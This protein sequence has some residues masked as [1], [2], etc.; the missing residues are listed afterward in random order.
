MVFPATFNFRNLDV[1]SWKYVFLWQVGN[2]LLPPSKSKYTG[3]FEAAEKQYTMIKAR[4][5]YSATWT[6]AVPKF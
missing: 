1:D 4:S 2:S 3:M 5:V 6:V